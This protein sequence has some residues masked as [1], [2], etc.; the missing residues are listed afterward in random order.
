MAWHCGK[1][2]CP[3]HSS[4]EHV[5]HLWKLCP[6]RGSVGDGG[7]NAT[8][9]VRTIQGAL[10]RIADPSWGNARFATDGKPSPSFFSAIR[11]FQ[12]SFGASKPDGRVDPNG[13]TFRA[14]AKQSNVKRLVVYLASQTIEARE[15]GR[16]IH[17]FPCVTGADDHPTEPGIFKISRKHR[18][19]TSRKYGAQMDYAMFF[20]NDGKA[21]HQYH[22]PAGL[23]L[24]RLMKRNVSDW[25][26]S[27]GCVR[28]E[29]AHARKLFEWTPDHTVVQIY[30]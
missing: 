30:Q 24:V 1:R 21:I 29:E 5:C 9:D 6:I 2:G 8:G 15:D 25:F 3:T 16:V 17:R 14:L 22:G 18:H 11:G 27:H 7:K 20:S 19:H 4:V 10:N 13:K 12:Q 23:S 26:G 28:L